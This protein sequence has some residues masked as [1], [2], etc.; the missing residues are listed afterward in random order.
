M[1]MLV[2]AAIT[3]GLLL[4]AQSAILLASHSVPDAKSKATALVAGAAALE[5]LNADLAFATAVP[6]RTATQIVMQVPDRTGDGL[7]ETITWTWSG[8]PGTPLLRTINAGASQAVLPSVQ[9]FALAYDTRSVR[10]PQTYSTSAETLLSSYTVTT[11]AVSNRINSSQTVGQYFKPSL[12]ANA[13]S[14]AVT[15]VQ[16]M[17]RIHGAKSGEA[18]IQ[19]GTVNNL[20]TPTGKIVDQFSQIEGNLTSAFT[21]QTYTYT[22]ATGLDPALGLAILVKWVSDADACD[23]QSAP[24]TLTLANANMLTSTTGATWTAS[25]LSDLNYYV[26]GTYSTP[27]PVA[28][29][30]YLVGVRA[31]VRTST[32]AQATARS[33]VCVLNE[34]QVPGP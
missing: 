28:Y 5:G 3:A 13:T 33:T 6:T 34:P 7:D 14:W 15:R 26:Y 16:L 17:S 24:V 11:G 10:A 29:T 2:A 4:A 22:A 30:Y 31:S 20:G 27:D 32:D 9:S 23:I 25:L 19:L 12:P 21:W 1:E 18:L 8:V